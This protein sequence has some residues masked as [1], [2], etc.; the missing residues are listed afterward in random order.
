MPSPQRH[1][2]HGPANAGPVVQRLDEGRVR[3]ALHHARPRPRMW[4]S[5]DDRLLVLGTGQ[6]RQQRGD[7]AHRPAQRQQAKQRFGYRG[8]REFALDGVEAAGRRLAQA[9]LVLLD[10]ARSSGLTRGPRATRPRA[11]V[12]PVSS[13]RP[14]ASGAGLRPVQFLLRQ[15]PRLELAQEQFAASLTPPGC[16][17]LAAQLAG[18]QVGAARTMDRPFSCE[19]HQVFLGFCPERGWLLSQAGDQNLDGLAIVRIGQRQCRLEPNAGIGIGEQG[20]NGFPGGS[21]RRPCTALAPR[22]RGQTP[23]AP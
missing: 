3:L 16:P 21:G 17:H 4:P 7:S 14:P 9:R 11:A 2:R 13:S 22:Q 1:R 5:S 23:A 6:E 18:N 15:R 20:A 10:G 19:P 8:W 12:P